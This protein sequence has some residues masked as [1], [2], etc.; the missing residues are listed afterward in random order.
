VGLEKS[1]KSGKEKRKPYRKGKAFDPLC[2][3]HNWC[4]V[5]KG[6]RLYSITK[7][8]EKSKSLEQDQ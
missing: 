1:I 8:L 5:C 2:R 4:P 6:N 3:N 7:S